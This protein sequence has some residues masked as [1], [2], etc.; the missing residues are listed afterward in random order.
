MECCICKSEIELVGDW[1]EG[2]NAD[3][4]QDG[5]C[6]G[7]CN[8]TV[9]LP[10]RLG[11]VEQ[12]LKARQRNV[13]RG[14]PPTLNPNPA[15]SAVPWPAAVGDRSCSFELPSVTHEECDMCNGSGAIASVGPC[16]A[17]GGSGRI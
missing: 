16:P 5:R 1:S 3:P 2:H 15:A 4:V 6:C 13:G 17:C 8:A 7:S 12:T 14:L 10:A 11:Q 9:V